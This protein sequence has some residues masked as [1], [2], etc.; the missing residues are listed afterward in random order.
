[1]GNAAASAGAAGPSEGLRAGGSS[2]RTKP[3]YTAAS[4]PE[5]ADTS[6]RRAGLGARL[7]ATLDV[8][9]ASSDV[10]SRPELGRAGPASLHDP[11]LAGPVWPAETELV[12][13]SH[14]VTRTCVSLSPTSGSHLSWC[15]ATPRH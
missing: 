5:R 2:W 10:A 15:E 12:I 13:F 14:G 1:M 11:N 9:R 7:L 4:G 3:E 8:G 6:V